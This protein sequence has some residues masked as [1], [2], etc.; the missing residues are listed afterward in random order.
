MSF[1]DKY[2]NHLCWQRAPIARWRCST[3]GRLQNIAKSSKC[4]V[5]RRFRLLSKLVSD[6]ENGVSLGRLV[7]ARNLLF[8]NSS[9]SGNCRQE[10]EPTSAVPWANHLLWQHD[11]HVSLGIKKIDSTW[12]GCVHWSS[13]SYGMSLPRIWTKQSS[14]FVEISKLSLGWFLARFHAVSAPIS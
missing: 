12:H 11:G 6:P 14:K 13:E 3:P 5:S 9:Q 1:W 7:C 4:V 10:T 2:K 8:G